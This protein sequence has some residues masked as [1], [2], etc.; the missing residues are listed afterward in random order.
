MEAQVKLL[1]DVR[2]PT[3]RVKAISALPVSAVLSPLGHNPFVCVCVGGASNDFQR[4]LLRPSSEN[5]SLY[6]NS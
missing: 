4:N 1:C 5:R 3:V 2:S 6:Y